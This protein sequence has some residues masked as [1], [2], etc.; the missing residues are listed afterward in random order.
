MLWRACYSLA[1]AA[2]SL[3]NHTQ[4]VAAIVC[5]MSIGLEFYCCLSFVPP[6]YYD[7]VCLDFRVIEPT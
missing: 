4:S 2:D 6:G 7:R 3:R 5:T 1:F